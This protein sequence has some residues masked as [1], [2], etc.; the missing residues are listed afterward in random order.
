MKGR[1]WRAELA[2]ARSVTSYLISA[3]KP[4]DMHVSDE[5]IPRFQC[6]TTMTVSETTYPTPDDAAVVRAAERL[7]EE[8]MARYDPSHD[9]YHGMLSV[10]QT[11]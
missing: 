6:A 10:Q 8:T 3:S 11:R 9:A 2:P 5:S 4:R 1:L 7:M